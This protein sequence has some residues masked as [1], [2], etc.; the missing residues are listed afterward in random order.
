V[1]GIGLR[2]AGARWRKRRDDLA[3]VLAALLDRL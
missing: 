1:V 2:L 3:E